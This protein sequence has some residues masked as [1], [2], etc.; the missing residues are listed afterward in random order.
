MYQTLCCIVN[1]SRLFDPE[2]IRGQI[3][4]LTEDRAR[5]DRAIESLEN[6]LR[7]IERLDSTQPQLSFDASDKEMTL[8][9]AVKRCCMEMTDGITRQGVVKMIELNYPHLRPKS[10]SVAASLVNLTKGDQPLL[11]VALEGKGRSPS[12]YSTAGDTVL[13]LGKDEIEG[14]LDPTATHGTGGWQ[15]LWGALLKQFNKTKGTITLTPEL[16]ARIYRYYREYGTGGWQNKAK[17]VF[18]RELPHLFS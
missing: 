11:K 1:M 10:A 18:R 17:R 6:A 7:S 9:D 13:K 14:L 12:F 8:H 15:S 16:R 3:A 2:A 5:I 4:N